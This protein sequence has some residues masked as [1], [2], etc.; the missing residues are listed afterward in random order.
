MPA[1]EVLFLS[2]LAI[3][4]GLAF[5]FY[6]FRLFFFLL[7]IWAFAVGF[8][9]GAEGMQ[10]LF[11]EG[12]LST[13]TSYVVGFIIGIGFAL[14]S[15][16]FWWAAVTLLGAT[17]GYAVG[18]GILVAIGLEPGFITF[19]AGIVAGVALALAFIVLNMPSALVIVATAIGGAGYAVGGL[20]LLLGQAT[21]A[22]LRGGGPIGALEGKPLGIAIWIGLAAIGIGYQYLEMR[23]TAY[24][25]DRARYRYA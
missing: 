12:F 1:L 23:R 21:Q 5:A 14:L 24:E 11:G 7:P 20:W 8:I 10:T 6:G 25:I 9:F 13:V 17:I 3:V 18:S 4:I 22:E 19:V 16:L 2:L 15:Y